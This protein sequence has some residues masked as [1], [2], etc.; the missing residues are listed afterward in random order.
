MPGNFGGVLPLSYYNYLA[1]DMANSDSTV[2]VSVNVRGSVSEDIN[3]QSI[4]ENII[5][6]VSQKIKKGL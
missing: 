2:A 5:M 6:E 1:E 3:R 4:T